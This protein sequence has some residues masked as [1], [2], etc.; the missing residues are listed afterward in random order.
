MLM[1]DFLVLLSVDV[2]NFLCI[3]MGFLY[4]QQFDASQSY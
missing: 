3:F 4:V 2:F 1:L